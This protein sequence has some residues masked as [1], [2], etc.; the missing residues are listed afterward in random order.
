MRPLGLEFCHADYRMA[1]FYRNI[2]NEY[3]HPIF[4]TKYGEPTCE[5]MRSFNVLK[6]LQMHQYTKLSSVSEIF[7]NIVG[8]IAAMSFFFN[9]NERKSICILHA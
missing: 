1:V 2:Y 8:S 6:Y 7:L 9:L 3:L 5:Y 4:S